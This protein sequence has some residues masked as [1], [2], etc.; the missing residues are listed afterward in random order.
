MMKKVVDQYFM[1]S[2]L[3][4]VHIQRCIIDILYIYCIVSC[5]LLS[6]LYIFSMLIGSLSSA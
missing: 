5:N 1:E 3:Y 4:S 2:V 6:L